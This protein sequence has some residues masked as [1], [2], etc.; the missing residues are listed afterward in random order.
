MPGVQ[1]VLLGAGD[2]LLQAVTS[3]TDDGF[4]PVRGAAPGLR[5]NA[6]GSAERPT[7]RPDSPLA[8]PL[9]TVGWRCVRPR[10]TAGAGIRLLVRPAAV[11]DDQTCQP[12]PGTRGQR[13]V[14]VGHEDL[15][16]RG[17]CRQ[18]APHHSRRSSRIN[19]N[20][21]V[22]SHDQRPRS[23]QLAVVC[24]RPFAAAVRR[25]VSGVHEPSRGVR[26][27]RTS[28]VSVGSGPTAPN[29]HDQD[30]QHALGDHIALFGSD[31]LWPLFTA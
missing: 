4:G 21:I 17:G 31:Q 25:E 1:E 27:D 18:T 13:C 26:H 10:S 9:G 20:H 8:R 7:L 14:G 16:G 23:V 15:L 28:S 6:A 11:L 24:R 2:P 22:S 19:I 5:G 12:E 29:L 3:R 30:R